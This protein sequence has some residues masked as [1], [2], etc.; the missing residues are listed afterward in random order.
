ME[1]SQRHGRQ[2]RVREAAA[3][4]YATESLT[5]VLLDSDVI[6][7]VLRGQPEVIAEMI[8]LERSGAATYSTAIAWAEIYAGIRPGEEGPTRAF[9]SARGDVVLDRETGQRAGEYMA[10]YRSSHGVELADALVAA[11]ASTSG[12]LLWTF[13]RRHYPMADLRFYEPR[14]QA[15]GRLSTDPDA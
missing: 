6:I 15:E 4:G 7:E 1:R 12:L 10:R 11:A 14:I 2:P 9:F 8:A 13:N 5:G 3:E